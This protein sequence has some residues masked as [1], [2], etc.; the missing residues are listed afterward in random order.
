M[1]FRDVVFVASFLVLVA[2]GLGRLP[3]CKA[4]TKK[5]DG[6]SEAVGASGEAV[7]VEADVVKGASD[8]IKVEL[9]AVEKKVPVSAGKIAGQTEVLDRSASNLIAISFALS[10]QSKRVG[11]LETANAEYGEKL[12]A[13]DKEIQDVRDAGARRGNAVFYIIMAICSAIAIGGIWVG[14]AAKSPSI[15]ALI[16][17]PAGLGVLLMLTLIRYGQV[18]AFGG[19]VLILIGIAAVVGVG[20]LYLIR[21]FKNGTLGISAGIDAA[22]AEFAKLPNAAEVLA[23]LRQSLSDAERSF[24]AQSFLDGLRGKG[25]AKTG[26]K[27]E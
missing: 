11:E 6:S 19:L 24:G 10:D 4:S 20:V 12:A 23:I 14:W 1:R 22:K 13:K 7:K 8:R 18:L 2:V 15:A 16:S 25:K 5:S 3:G 27:S 26:E 17:A 9:P 21:Q